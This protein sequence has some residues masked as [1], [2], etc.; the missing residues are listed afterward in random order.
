MSWLPPPARMPPASARQMPSDPPAGAS[1]P[2]TQTTLGAS[3]VALCQELPVSG[4]GVVVRDEAADRRVGP[5]R[6]DRHHQ[7]AL[8][9]LLHRE[10]D[11][12]PVVVL[13]L[14][15]GGGALGHGEVAQPRAVGRVAVL[16]GAR[17]AGL[18]EDRDGLDHREALGGPGLQ[19]LLGLGAGEV[20]EQAPRRVGEPEER[21]ARPRE[22]AALDADRRRGRA[23][24]AGRRLVRRRLP[25]GA[26]ASLGPDHPTGHHPR[27]IDPVP[28][29]RARDVTVATRELGARG[30]R[31]RADGR[32]EQTAENDGH[33]GRG[34]HRQ[35][36]DTGAERSGHGP[37]RTHPGGRMSAGA[38]ALPGAAAGGIRTLGRTGSTRAGTDKLAPSEMIAPML[39]RSLPSQVRTGLISAGRTRSG[40]PNVHD[41]YRRVPFA[42]RSAHQSRHTSRVVRRSGD[43]NDLVGA[44]RPQ[45]EH[46]G[47]HRSRTKGGEMKIA[48]ILDTKGHT[49][50]SVL[51]FGTRSPRSSRGSARSESERYSSATRTR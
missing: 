9:G 45:Q 4:G 13:L 29:R 18:R 8:G 37:P 39:H 44:D 1:P 7:A 22:R 3:A 5:H 49:V 17:P 51:P 24:L 26:R 23:A 33:G 28:G 30:Q 16:V 25:R 12:V 38:T 10:V 42:S 36:A 50:H 19:V 46:H 34:E 48:A 15:V 47:V 31:G 35:A 27:R 20:H 32:D 11:L 41:R 6:Q 43:Q 21:L 40:P 14:V 2:S